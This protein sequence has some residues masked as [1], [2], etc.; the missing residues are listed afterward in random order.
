MKIPSYGDAIVGIVRE[1]N[2]E[3]KAILQGETR[4]YNDT[5]RNRGDCRHSRDG[6]ACKD[7]VGIEK[8][9]NMSWTTV[10]EYFDSPDGYKVHRGGGYA[11]KEKLKEELPVSFII[12][13]GARARLII[14]EN[15]MV[16]FAKSMPGWWHRFWYRLL[17]GWRWEE[18]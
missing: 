5:E 12:P 2:K 6:V 10:Q 3:I 17:L 1:M 13:P 9:A 7:V 4:D 8:G 11:N 18:L 16:E 15:F 14:N